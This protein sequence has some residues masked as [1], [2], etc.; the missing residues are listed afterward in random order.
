MKNENYLGQYPW[1]F[2]FA[3]GSAKKGI[4]FLI[5]SWQIRRYRKFV[6]PSDEFDKKVINVRNKMQSLW[7]GYFSKYVKSFSLDPVKNLLIISTT[8]NKPWLNFHTIG[9]NP[10]WSNVSIYLP[11]RIKPTWN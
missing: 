3:K 9:W 6:K 10:L 4:F 8:I 5:V 11:H 1:W 2:V 7:L